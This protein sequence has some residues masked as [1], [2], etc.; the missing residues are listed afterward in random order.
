MWLR[1]RCAGVPLAAQPSDSP[2]EGM[3]WMGYLD[4]MRHHLKKLAMSSKMLPLLEGAGGTY[5]PMMRGV[6]GGVYPPMSFG[7]QSGSFG[8][9]IGVAL[10]MVASV[11][12]NEPTDGGAGMGEGLYQL[13]ILPTPRA[14][15]TG[16]AGRAGRIGAAM[17]CGDHAAVSAGGMGTLTLGTFM[18]Y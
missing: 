2:R 11:R 4:A 18:S 3:G 8:V 13:G 10:G 14:P 12:C 5:P 9:A 17:S 6:L 1:L 7:D 16:V 15:T